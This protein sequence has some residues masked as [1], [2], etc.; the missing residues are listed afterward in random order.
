[1]PIVRLPDPQRE[2]HLVLRDNR[3]IF[4]RPIKPDDDRLIAI[5]WDM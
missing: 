3:R 5:F 4:V 2:R 1:M